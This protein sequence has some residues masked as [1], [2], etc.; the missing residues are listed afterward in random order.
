MLRRTFR[1]SGPP[2]NQNT[3]RISYTELPQWVDDREEHDVCIG[4]PSNYGSLSRVLL[5]ERL[6]LRDAIEQAGVL[7]EELAAERDETVLA[8]E[9]APSA[10][11]V[12]ACADGC[13]IWL[14]FDLGS[15]IKK[16]THPVLGR[17]LTLLVWVRPASRATDGASERGFAPKAKSD[18]S[19][20]S[21]QLT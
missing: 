14:D 2:K 5:R 7:A 18:S 9:Q 10:I 20:T 6:H 16:P 13:Q 11:H 21:D 8:P 3:A 1:N 15:R 17:R 19:D 12:V 4:L